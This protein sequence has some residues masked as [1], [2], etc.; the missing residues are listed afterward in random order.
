MDGHLVT[1]EVSVETL[2][3]QRVKLNGRSINHDHFESLNTHAMQRRCTIEHH[4]A[5]LDHV[6]KNF[7]DFFVAALK[8]ALGGF[9]GFGIAALFERANDE[10]L[11]QLKNDTLRQAAL[12][13]LEARTNHDD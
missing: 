2:T 7:P 11:E 12:V 1:V 8:L 4:H 3:H 9:D 13:Q 10:R 6:I 5:A